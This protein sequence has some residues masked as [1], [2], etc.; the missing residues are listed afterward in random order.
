MDKLRV[1][2]RSAIKL[3]QKSL[4][5]M[6]KF[7]KAKHGQECEIKVT[8]DPELIAGFKINVAGLEYDYSLSGSLDQLEQEL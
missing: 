3:D 4:L 7:I 5:S 1:T 2:V 8:I 6:A